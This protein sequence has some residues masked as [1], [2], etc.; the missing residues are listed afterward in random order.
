MA[1]SASTSFVAEATVE[2]SDGISI[3]PSKK[4]TYVQR[5]KE[6]AQKLAKA[7]WQKARDKLKYEESHGTK[8]TDSPTEISIARTTISDNVDD[9]VNLTSASRRKLKLVKE[10]IGPTD[11]VKDVETKERCI[12]ELETL[13]DL[14]AMFTCSEC[15]TEGSFDVYFG[16]RMG[17]SRQIHIKCQRCPFV[18]KKYSCS[19]KSNSEQANKGFDV[20]NAMVVCFNELGLGYA[21]LKKFSALVNIPGMHSTTYE[22]LTKHVGEAHV[23]VSDNVLNASAEAVRK[24]Y[25]DLDGCNIGD[26]DNVCSSNQPLD[27]MVSFD[28]TWHKRGFASNYGVGI[29]I[30][31]MTGLVLDYEVLSKYCSACEHNKAKDM[32]DSE[33]AEWKHKHQADCKINFK[34][35]SKAMEKE[36][37]VRMWTRSIEK[38][39]MR[40][41]RMLSDGDS[42]AH[43][44]VIDAKAYGDTKIEKL[45]CVNHCHKR[46]GTA[47]RKKAKE[48]KLGGKKF[49]SLT[50]HTCNVLQTYYRNAVNEHLGNPDGMKRAI[51]ASLLHCM[52][53]DENPQ[54]HMCPNGSSSWCFYNRAAAKGETPQSHKKKIKTPISYEVARAIYPIY[55]RMSDLNLLRRMQ[56]GLTQNANESLNSVIWA[57]CPKTTFVGASRVKAAVASAVSHFNQGSSHLSQVMKQLD[58]VPSIILQAYQEHQDRKRCRKADNEALPEAK[59]RRKEKQKKKKLIAAQQERSEGETYSPGMLGLS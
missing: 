41:S 44:A 9:F 56:H 1:E 39:N 5:K 15:G 17:Y 4:K 58:V 55:E 8:I 53:T 16:E 20:N 35:S 57:R 18:A 38:H 40:Y 14:F 52:S 33:R 13:K 59:Q 46:I 12:I 42:I 22:K 54:H 36:A 19:R 49:G 25:A 50:V 28:G 10:K 26:S 31:V 32:S 30:E 29:V 3:Y 45:E 27:V 34:G 11:A 47:L 37:A 7:R 43:K 6:R 48:E 24:V 23:N 21:A 51:W 2:V